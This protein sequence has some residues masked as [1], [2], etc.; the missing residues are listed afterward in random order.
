MLREVGDALER[1][2]TFPRSR[3]LTQTQ[4]CN[5]TRHRVIPGQEVAGVMH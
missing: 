1:I 2:A 3:A 4:R 5:Q